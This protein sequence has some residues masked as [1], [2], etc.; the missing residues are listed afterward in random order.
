[1]PEQIRD[2][3][4]RVMAG[5]LD[6]EDLQAIASAIQTGQINLVSGKGAIG[7][8]RDAVNS[9]IVPGNNNIIESDQIFV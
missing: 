4:E 8:G 3:I 1:M 2:I 6:V 5:S 7:I 9:V